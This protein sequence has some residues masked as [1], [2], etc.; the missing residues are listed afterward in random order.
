MT[1]SELEQRWMKA[2]R[3][4]SPELERIRNRELSE[5]SESAGAPE[6]TESAAKRESSGLEIF[7]QWMMRWRVQLLMNESRN[8]SA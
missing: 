2:W 3:Y 4:A 1:N 8:K 6:Q 7:Q 5:L